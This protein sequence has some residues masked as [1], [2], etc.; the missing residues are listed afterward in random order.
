LKL[1]G[2]IGASVMYSF[3]E[4]RVSAFAKEVS[5]WFWLPRTWRSLPNVCRG[6]TARRG[7]KMSETRTNG[8]TLCTLYPSDVQCFEPAKNGML[9]VCLSTFDMCICCIWCLLLTFKDT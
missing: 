4:R 8:C 1:M 2:V 3:F 9:L 7:T 6:T 5:I